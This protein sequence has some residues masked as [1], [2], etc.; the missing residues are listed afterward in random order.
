MRCTIAPEWFSCVRGAIPGDG[1]RSQRCSLYDVRLVAATHCDLT[2]MVSCSAYCRNRSL[3]V[4]GVLGLTESPRAFPGCRVPTTCSAETTRI[5]S[6]IVRPQAIDQLVDGNSRLGDP[7]LL[8]QRSGVRKARE[9]AL[10]WRPNSLHGQRRRIFAAEENGSE[11]RPVLTATC[12]AFSIRLPMLPSSSY[13][14][15]SIATGTDTCRYK[16]RCT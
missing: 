1:R 15:N 10:C 16:N 7:T 4:W 8:E 14:A 6:F 9:S 12:A 2:D 11:T 13:E 3:S 5:V